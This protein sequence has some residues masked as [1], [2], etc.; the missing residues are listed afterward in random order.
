MGDGY[1]LIHGLEYIIMAKYNLTHGLEYIVGR[2][3]GVIFGGV[4]FS[5]YFCRQILEREH[6]N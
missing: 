2:F 5:S 6:K 4:V 1:N 3:L